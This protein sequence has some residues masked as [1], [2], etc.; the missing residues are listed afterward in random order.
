MVV[1]FPAC[2]RYY[3]NII[4]SSNI[5]YNDHP[6]ETIHMGSWRVVG[7]SVDRYMVSTFPYYPFRDYREVH[8]DLRLSHPNSIY[9]TRV[10]LSVIYRSV[11][12][13]IPIYLFSTTSTPQHA[14]HESVTILNF[15]IESV[16]FKIVALKRTLPQSITVYLSLSQLPQVFH[17]LFIWFYNR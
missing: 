2:D 17:S 13:S 6:L 8:S 3:W 15:Y 10:T 5:W 9:L 4:V 12:S 14:L 7:Y 16:V 1:S 11:L